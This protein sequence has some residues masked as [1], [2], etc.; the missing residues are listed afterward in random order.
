MLQLL[1]HHAR[2]NLPNLIHGQTVIYSEKVMKAAAMLSTTLN[3]SFAVLR[4]KLSGE[5]SA[6][7]KGFET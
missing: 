4:E 1:A 2:E 6:D 3:Q 7:F 5:A